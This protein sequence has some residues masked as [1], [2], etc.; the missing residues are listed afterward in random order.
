[1]EICSNLIMKAPEWRLEVVLVSL[2]FIASF[3]GIWHIVFGILI[4]DF[5]QVNFSWVIISFILPSD[6]KLSNVQFLKLRKRYCITAQDQYVFITPWTQ[7]VH[8]TYI[9]SSENVVRDVF[10]TCY[11]SSIYD[12]YPGGIFENSPILESLFQAL[13]SLNNWLVDSQYRRVLTPIARLKLLLWIT[14]KLFWSKVFGITLNY[15]KSNFGTDFLF[16]L[17]KNQK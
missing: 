8:W 7:D 3:T 16:Y 14:F 5:E 13:Q 10:W 6:D 1:M 2:F 4:I 9:R 17:P 11:A 12:L 15:G